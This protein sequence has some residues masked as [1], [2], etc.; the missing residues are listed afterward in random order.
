MASGGS[1][2]PTPSQ[3][4]A[5]ARKE[6]DEKIINMINNARPDVLWVGLG[7]PKQDRWIFEHKKQLGNTR[8]ILPPSRNQSPA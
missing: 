6:E 1:Q 8:S 7:L 5:E 4:R 3:V 2:G